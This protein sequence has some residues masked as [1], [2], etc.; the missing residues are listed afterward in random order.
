MY[1]AVLK[2]QEVVTRREVFPSR[3]E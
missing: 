3:G 1:P 2:R